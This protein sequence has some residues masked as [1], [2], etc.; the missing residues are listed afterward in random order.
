EAVASGNLGY[1]LPLSR[2]RGDEF[3]R[4]SASFEEMTKQ[5]IELDKLK[6]E[7]VSVASHELKTPINVVQGYVQLLDEGVYGA[8]SEKQRAV[9]QTLES[10]LQALARLVKHLLD[11]SRCEAGGGKLEPRVVQRGP[12]REELER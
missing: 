1:K 3:G 8:L 2:W 7:F 9:L 12:F 11:V 10:Q 4:L 6:A 5:L